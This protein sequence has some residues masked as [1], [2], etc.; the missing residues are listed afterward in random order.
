MLQKLIESS[1]IQTQDFSPH[2]MMREH[3]SLFHPEDTIW[4]ARKFSDVEDK[5]FN[6]AQW[7]LD[8]LPIKYAV[9][10]TASTYRQGCNLSRKYE[11][12]KNNKYYVFE[13]DKISKDEV[14][15][16]FLDSKSKGMKL[17][18]VVDSGNKSIHG[19]VKKDENIN[20]WK[21]LYIKYGFCQAAMRENQAL[22]LA[23]AIRFFKDHR[24]PT[25]QELL[26]LDKSLI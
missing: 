24:Q 14:A 4:I 5:N 25:V 7:W 8:N 23:G 12:I 9:Y 18:A 6:T 17:V 15:E 16:Y 2:Q 20:F 10:I 26:Y 13:H 3:I 21:D 22:R 19:W 1:P 11:N